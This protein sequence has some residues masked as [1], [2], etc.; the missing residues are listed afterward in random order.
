MTAAERGRQWYLLPSFC[1]ALAWSSAS[2]KKYLNL[3]CS[4]DGRRLL[5]AAWLAQK[6]PKAVVCRGGGHKS[7]VWFLWLFLSYFHAEV[8]SGKFFLSSS[9][10]ISPAEQV[11]FILSSFFS[12][13][14]VSVVQCALGFHSKMKTRR[15][16]TYLS[17]A[18][19]SFQCHRVN[20]GTI[21]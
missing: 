2:V 6:R 13:V 5:D 8:H 11:F 14:T 4:R 3:S 19:S 15:K 17:P 1:A 21:S 12:I 18:I 10:F 16:V 7:V 9:S 20:L